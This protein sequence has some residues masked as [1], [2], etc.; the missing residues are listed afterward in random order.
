MKRSRNKFS[1]LEIHPNNGPTLEELQP[2]I[3]EW[4]TEVLK[5]SQRLDY[6]SLKKDNNG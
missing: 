5:I 6:E 1:I 3:K 4:I 2:K